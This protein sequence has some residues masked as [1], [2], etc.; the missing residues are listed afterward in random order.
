MIEKPM[1]IARHIILVGRVQGLGVRPAIA[2][3][4]EIADLWQTL[5]F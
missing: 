2:R 4:A 3:L 1:T 5:H